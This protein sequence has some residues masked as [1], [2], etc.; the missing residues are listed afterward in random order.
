MLEI[1]NIKDTTAFPRW[2]KRCKCWI[3]S[4]R[5]WVECTRAPP[6]EYCRL[7]IEI[8]IDY[9]LFVCYVMC[10]I[11][12]EEY[13][14]ML[15]RMVLG[16]VDLDDISKFRWVNRNMMRNGSDS[17]RAAQKWSSWRIGELVYYISA[18]IIVQLRSILVSS[19]ILCETWKEWVTW[20]CGIILE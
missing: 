7:F 15:V 20:K 17:Q 8:V 16:F 18:I 10:Q 6:T 5:Q 4:E 13:C 9:W 14:A 12:C 3:E 1:E 2:Y 19:L 11:N